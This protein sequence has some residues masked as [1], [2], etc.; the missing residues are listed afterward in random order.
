MIK[1]WNDPK[2]QYIRAQIYFRDPEQLCRIANDEINWVKSVSEQD[3]FSCCLCYQILSSPRC[4]KNCTIF[5]CQE[6]KMEQ[7]RQILCCPN[8]ACYSSENCRPSDQYMEE[9]NKLFVECQNEGCER[10]FNVANEEKEMIDHFKYKC[11]YLK[12]RCTYCK[13]F[14]I[15]RRD[16][17]RHLTTQCKVI[18][19]TCQV[20]MIQYNQNDAHNC[21]AAMAKLIDKL[22]KQVQQNELHIEQMRGEIVKDRN[23]NMF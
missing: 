20:C 19:K 6:C 21:V 22:S 17:Q 10:T 11:P 18:P 4:C 1:N 8:Y 16:I 2:I 14:P 7:V 3:K 12:M 13:Q 9:Y 23:M 5:Y 15:F